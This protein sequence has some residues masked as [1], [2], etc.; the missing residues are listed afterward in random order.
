MEQKNNGQNHEKKKVKI[1]NLIIPV[2]VK[3]GNS[4]ASCKMK[5]AAVSSK[6]YNNTLK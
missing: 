6:F 1:G 2:E 3:A 4:G 5:E